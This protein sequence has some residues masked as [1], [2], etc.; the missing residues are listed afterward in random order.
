MKVIYLYTDG[1]R[2]IGVYLS[3]CFVNLYTLKIHNFL[4]AKHIYSGL[5]RIK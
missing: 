4:H 5:K 1:G 3:P 2:F